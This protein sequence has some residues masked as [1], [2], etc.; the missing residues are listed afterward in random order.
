MR[1]SM[2]TGL[3]IHQV[4]RNEGTVNDESHQC[5][6]RL[7]TIN[8]IDGQLL[9]LT[10]FHL[11]GAFVDYTILFEVQKRLPSSWQ[12]RI[13]NKRC[14]NG[15]KLRDSGAVIVYLIFNGWLCVTIV[16]LERKKPGHIMAIPSTSYGG[17]M[18][19]T[20]GPELRK[21]F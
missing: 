7:C 2:C 1:S 3:L 14:A 8:I 15:P 20:P 5:I 21:S 11:Q 9:S 19:T 17:S 18:S 13:L 16:C 12:W 10:Y 6:T 4:L